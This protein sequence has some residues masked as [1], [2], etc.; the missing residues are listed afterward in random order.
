MNV[1]HPAIG[2]FVAR[3][4][5]RSMLS[6]EEAHALLNLS[7]RAAQL[8]AHADII[9]PGETVSHA[10]LVAKGLVGRFDQMRDGKR[11]IAAFH[12]PGDMCDLHS[13]VAP[14]AGWGMGALSATTVLFV[15]HAELRKLALGY[16]N[17]SL[18]FWRDSTADA[19]VLAKWVGN[20]GRQEAR[21]RLAHL[22]CETGVR[23]ELAELGTRSSFVLEATQEQLADALGLTAV[24]VNRTMQALRRDGLV[25]THGRTIEIADWQRLAQ[26]ADFDPAYLLLDLPTRAHRH[27]APGSGF[28]GLPS[29]A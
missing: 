16:P 12:I 26:V 6:S 10:C 9:Y 17:V 2:K 24:H 29:A 7:F 19:S 23:L 11:Q 14:T 21:A 18:A 4:L 25:A 5:R 1:G 22:L 28:G 27:N 8:P 13:V 3:L 20:L 15:P